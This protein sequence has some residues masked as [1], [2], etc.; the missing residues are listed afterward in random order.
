[1]RTPRWL[2]TIVC[3]LIL[4]W[5]EMSLV[6]SQVSAWGCLSTV[7]AGLTN[8]IAISSGL[9]FDLALSADGS[10][11]AWGRN[12]VT[13]TN[14]TDAVAISAGSPQSLAL[15]ANGTV[16]AWGGD[17]SNGELTVPL[18]LDNVVSVSAGFGFNLALRGDGTVVAWGCTNKMVNDYGQCNVP[19]GLTNVT[20]LS[21]GSSH[22]LALRSDGTVVAWGLNDSG[23]CNVPLGLSNV[24]AVS[25]GETHSLA[26]R[27]DGTVVGWGS[28]V[29]GEQNPP[30]DL[31]NAVAVVA[32][33]N[34][35]L[36]L[37][38]DGTL[39]A[40]GQAPSVPQGLTNVTAI[41]GRFCD[42]APT[43]LA[44][45]GTPPKIAISYIG[46]INQTVG[47][48]SQAV[49]FV[50]AIGSLPLSY[51]WYFGTNLLEGATSRY[52]TL[53]NVEESQSG[54]YTVVVTNSLGATS[55]QPV[56][57]SVTPTA[58]IFLVPAIRLAGTPGDLIRIDYIN[59]VGPTN[60]WTSLATITLTNSQQFYSDYSAIGQ[61]TRLY[62][63]VRLP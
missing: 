43:F 13:E 6:A 9:Y 47:I 42:P 39:V 48:G 61:Q 4:P 31:S 24:T 3:L 41:S 50:T 26:L 52:L 16:V 10:I 11:T 51:Q 54:T 32:D 59:A 20:A 14:V 46:P 33:I 53:N 1:M 17:N 45:A 38:A 57:L 22:S 18:G 29:Y 28:N 19:A 21:A 49:F 44:L 12:G 58:N 2:V 62:R 30:S 37:K 15:R 56:T 34:C 27:G 40:W 23:Q 63:I 55:S 36:A 35:S 5:F 60:D 7:P 8:V 25:A